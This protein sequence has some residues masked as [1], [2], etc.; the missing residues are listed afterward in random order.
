MMIK[1]CRE[2]AGPKGLLVAGILTEDAVK[3]KKP[4]PILSFEER[5][6]I[7]S[8]IKYFDQVI[9]QKTYSPLSNLKKIKPNFLME[10][11]SHEEK[12]IQELLDYMRSINGKIIKVPYYDGQSSTKI[13]DLI[14]KKI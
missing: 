4:S 6:E 7:A 13:K 2:V 8:S 5:F 3:E 1:K 12:E 9:P 14:R 11:T 10:S